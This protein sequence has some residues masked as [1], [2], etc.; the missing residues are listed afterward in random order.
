MSLICFTKWHGNKLQVALRTFIPT[1]LHTELSFFIV[2]VEFSITNAYE[3][4][5]GI[6]QHFLP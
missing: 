4:P 5:A 6:P 1:Y 3:I 2:N